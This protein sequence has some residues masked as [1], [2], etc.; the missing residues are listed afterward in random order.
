NTT[1]T[2]TTTA[3]GTLDSVHP[4]IAAAHGSVWVAFEDG[5]IEAAGAAVQG[6]GAV[7]TFGELQSAFRSD[8]GRVPQLAIG[9]T[10]QVMVTYEVLTN[11]FQSPS[12]GIF[13]IGNFTTITTINGT[14][15][16]AASDLTG[17]AQIF[18]NVDPDGLGGA[19]FG[20]RSK[21][22]DTKVGVVDP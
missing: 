9:P 21:V 13:G 3:T 11:D 12:N 2:T 16:T 15:I 1:T 14:F 4:T 19:P 6:L 10:G 17:P 7:G 5:D 8:N 18:T 22:S 20:H